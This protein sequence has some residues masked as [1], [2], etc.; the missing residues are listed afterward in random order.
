MEAFLQCNHSGSRNCRVRAVIV[1]HQ[2]VIY[3]QDTTV[4]R[5]GL[6]GIDSSGTLISPEK[7]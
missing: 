7:I 6:E 4:I 1:N 5:T 2:L 3:V